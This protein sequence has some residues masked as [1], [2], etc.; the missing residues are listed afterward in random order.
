MATSSLVNYIPC[1]IYYSG[2]G[3]V[4]KSHMALV[5]PWIITHQA[6]LSLGFPRGKN[7]GVG[8]PFPSPGDLPN[9][10]IKPMS[11]ALQV[12]SYRLSHQD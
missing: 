6:P 1:T 7:T 10:G 11:S 4:V 9:P 2:G 5:T 12:D 3:L 8:S